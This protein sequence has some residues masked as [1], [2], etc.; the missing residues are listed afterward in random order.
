MFTST[1]PLFLHT[2]TKCVNG[3]HFG[4]NLQQPT[5]SKL[6]HGKGSNVD[7]DQTSSNLDKDVNGLKKPTRD[8]NTKDIFVSHIDNSNI[9]R[10]FNEV[11]RISGNRESD[12][13]VN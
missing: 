2:C 12:C 3:G 4:I 13:D 6:L 7:N 10:M 1:F 5:L 8:I 11:D 9:E